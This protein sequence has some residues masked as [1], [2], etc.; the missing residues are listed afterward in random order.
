MEIIVP[1]PPKKG[2]KDT[3]EQLGILKD[4]LKKLRAL[5]EPHERAKRNFD[6]TLNHLTGLGVRSKHYL[7]LLDNEYPDG[8]E[9][10]LSQYDKEILA[11]F[12][13]VGDSD[14]FY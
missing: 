8:Y 2:K 11:Y 14:A 4:L 6:K 9:Q 12:T 1:S 3:A 7:L 5:R 13:K 10:L